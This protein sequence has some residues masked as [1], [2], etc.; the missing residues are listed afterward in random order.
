MGLLAPDEHAVASRASERPSAVALAIALLALNV[1]DLVLTDFGISSLGAREINP[2]MAPLIGTPWAMV[3]KFGIPLA[4]LA[5]ATQARTE[6]TVL[7][8]R[9]VVGLYI[10]L[11]IVTLS[12]IVL[13]V[14]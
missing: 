5:M 13:Y 1:L 7:L 11:I 4:V 14:A 9:I 8:L 6:R 10:V 3:V 12:Q 2:L